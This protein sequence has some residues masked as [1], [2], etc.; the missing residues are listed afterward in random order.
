MKKNIVFMLILSI[1]LIFLLNGCQNLGTFCPSPGVCVYPEEIEEEDIE[2]I[3]EIT[4]EIIVPPEEE[5]E[6]IEELP[7]EELE[8]IIEEFPEEA[9]IVVIEGELVKL[10]PEA[11][12]PEENVI[13]FT[14]SEPLDENGEWLTKTGDAGFYKT[15][16]I[17]SDGVNE[18]SQE[19]TI[20]VKEIANKPPVMEFIEDITVTEGDAIII[21]PVVTDPE[22][23]NILISYSGWMTTSSYT[24][25]YDDAGEYVVTVAA[26]DGVNEVFQDVNVIVNEFNRP[27]VMEKI[28]DIVLK[29]GDPVAVLVDATDPDGDE[30]TITYSEPLDED[31]T[32]ITEIGDADTYKTTVTLSDG[33]NEVSQDFNIIVEAVNRPPVIEIEDPI[34]VDEGQV[35]ILEP[36]VTDPEGDNIQL[37]YSGW[38][39]S[40]TYETTYDDAGEHIVTI[41]A[42]DGI[43][44][45]SKDITVIVNDVNRPPEF[46]KPY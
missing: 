41:T 19:V 1:S 14:F 32:W 13:I 26:S 17:A 5:L 9:D 44:E 33:I 24:T 25:T 4:G 16:I 34:E 28:D 31:G 30:L 36:I 8:E 3:E 15:T 35:V 29:E 10:S 21:E 27:P 43:N 42:S 46:T 39:T 45:V 12:D 23:D 38:M 2:G 20:L 40:D 22:G 6:E 18:V 7:E 37:T 11:K